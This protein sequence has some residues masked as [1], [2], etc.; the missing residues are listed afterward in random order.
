VQHRW[1]SY[2][3]CQHGHA[4]V[5][6]TYLFP[7]FIIHET[8]AKHPLTPPPPQ[9]EIATLE[10]Q[11]EEIDQKIEAEKIRIGYNDDD[12]GSLTIHPTSFFLPPSS[13]PLPFVHPPR[14][15]LSERSITA[16]RWC[17]CDVARG[18]L[19]CPMFVNTA[20]RLRPV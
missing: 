15:F 1:Y 11:L 18:L 4:V 7:P 19:S 2:Q 10:A 17:S 12:V 13:C 14:P 5:L 16:L 3:P 6:A 20:P 9:T 8:F